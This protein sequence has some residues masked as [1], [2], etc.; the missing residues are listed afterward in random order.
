LST[1]IRDIS[2]EFQLYSER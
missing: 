1:L 2:K